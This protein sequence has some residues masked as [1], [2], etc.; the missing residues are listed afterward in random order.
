MAYNIVTYKV[1]FTSRAIYTTANAIHSS[2]GLI[3]TWFQ[4]RHK[5]LQTRELLYNSWGSSGHGWSG[6]VIL[7]T[8]VLVSR[9]GC[10]NR[11][12]V[13]GKYDPSQIS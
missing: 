5:L 1:G 7:L 13:K 11:F 10:H 9:D 8:S 3:L 4:A 6:S 2:L 12:F